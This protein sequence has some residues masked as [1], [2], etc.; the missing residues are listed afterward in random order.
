MSDCSRCVS[1]HCIDWTIGSTLNKIREAAFKRKTNNNVYFGVGSY[2]NREERAGRCYRVTISGG[3]DRD[4]IFQ[5]VNRGI[6][7]PENNIDLMVGDGGFGLFDACLNSPVYQYNMTTPGAWGSAY[8]G[9]SNIKDCKNLPAYP[10]CGTNHYD[11][12]QE[13]CKWSFIH[14]LRSS[15]NGLPIINNLCEVACPEELYKAT[16]LLRSDVNVS[17]YTCTPA[18]T[19]PNGGHMTTMMDC[20]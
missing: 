14:H 20:G 7:V 3:L 6:D 10:V 13:L 15:S 17:S 9:V 11:S 19:E 4:V 5:V 18:S 12:M 8:G 1:Y 16:G 2:G